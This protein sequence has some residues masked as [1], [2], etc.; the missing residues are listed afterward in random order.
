MERLIAMFK[1]GA[2]Y[3][4][5][6]RRRY[7][8][9]LAALIFGFAV[10]TFVTSTKD[11][12]YDNA[13]F[14]AQ[15]HYAGDIVAVGHDSHGEGGFIHRLEQDD[16]AAIVHA[17]ELS[18]I[19]PQHI[20]LRT[21]FG[22]DAYVHHNGIAVQLRYLTGSD[23]ES[24]AHIFSRM[25]FPDAPEA[26]IGDDGII[27]S[28]PVA[29]QLCARMGD[30][31]ILE[32]DTPSGQK[33]TGVFIVRGI[34][35][36]T[37]IFG[38][39]K[40]YIA[41]ISLNRLLVYNDDDCSTI[42][43]FLGNPAA[44]EEKRI[45]LQAAL[46]DQIQ[47]GPLVHDRD[48]MVRERDKPWEGIRVFLYTMPVYLS[49]IA[50]LLGAMNLL[51]YFVYGM[52]LLTILVSA[53]VTYRLILHER[54]RE[55]GVMRTIG[56]YSRDMQ[57]ILWTEIIILGMLSIIAGFVLAF[58]LSWAASLVSFSWFP[59]FEIFLRNGRL[60]A[61]F[62]PQTMLTNVVLL[63]LILIVLALAPSFRVTRKSLPG[64]LSGEPL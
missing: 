42:G 43:F 6:Y 40:A 12:M 32:A 41:R 31:I 44:A 62:L 39:F 54:S 58:I 15:L 18:G 21:L 8:F 33:N 9:L 53:A 26:D 20:V 35:E 2:K 13:Y 63:L 60:S 4:Y 36:D 24:E 47:L 25:H 46:S 45:L 28:A 56:F 16:I 50:H 7:Y 10:V 5:R 17:A 38:F 59:G 64:L 57:L 11:G 29:R 37:S 23:W 55:M 27:L 1:L 30:S 49:E 3:L 34:F 19:N 48:G 22:I 14:A 51:T 61:L 52:I